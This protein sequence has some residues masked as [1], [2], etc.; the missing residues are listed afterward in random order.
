M[1][2]FAISF[3]LIFATSYLITSVIAP[4]KN[5]LGVIYLFIIAFAQIVFT[6]EILSL[7]SA[8]KQ[9]WVLFLNVLFLI[10]GIF[11]W[12]KNAKPLWS[13]ECKDFRNKVINSFKLDKSLVWLYVGFCIFLIVNTAL[14][15][16]FPIT[17]AD[18]ESYHSA[19]SL[20]WVLQGNL[21]H[22]VVPD[23]RNLCLPINSEILYSWVI[24]FT[25]KDI[26]F[27]FFSFVGYFLSIISLYNILCYC[28]YCTRKKLWI[29]FILSSFASVIVQASSTETDI[30]IAGLTLS[31][32]L[33]FWYGIRNNTKIPIFM[34]SLAYALA[35]G[36][37]TTALM[38]VPGVGILLLAICFYQKKYKPIGYFLMFGVINFV[39]FS[40]YN[41]ILNYVHFSNFM[42]A[43]SFM[44]VSKNYFGIKGM[45]SNF[46]KYMFLMID[47]TG[48]RWSDYFGPQVIAFR[49]N[50]LN[51]IHL[52]Y[53][54]DGLYST[55][56]TVNRY[57][58]EPVMGTG[59]LGI[60]TLIPCMIWSL[61]KPIFNFKNKKAWFTFIFAVVFVVNVLTMSYL[62]AY[63]AFSVRFLMG[64]IVISSPVLVYSYYSNKNPLKYLMIFFALF[65]FICISTH[66]WARPFINLGVI[67]SKHPSISYLRDVAHC[68]DFQENPQYIN[69]NCVL[70]DKMK[71]LFPNKKKILAFIGTSDRIYNFKALE[72]QGYK[73]DFRLL[74]NVSDINFNDYDL[75]ISTDKGQIS[76]LFNEYEQRKDDYVKINKIVHFKKNEEVPCFYTINPNIKGAKNKESLYPFQS[77]CQMTTRFIKKKNLKIIGYAGLFTPWEDPKNRD[78]NYYI[79]YLVDKNKK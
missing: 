72:F 37:K 10:L 12:N 8:I 44:V 2:L 58:L 74:E 35:I 47:F 51:F 40:S 11:V 7:F 41:Y 52:G 65:Y 56:I 66:L 19:R 67:F 70:I 31:T 3:L 64:F 49:D 18:A 53:I 54:K 24:L 75:V 39:I 22:F 4:K 42:G 20:F 28:G 63:M 15:F 48:F 34:A 30:I 78:F 5:I 50:L 43:K 26:F 59:V 60:F 25:K 68:K 6:F 9:F 46:V 79:I 29:I 55:N 57:L 77:K 69:A 73:V 71:L 38:A 45:I 14:C 36:T 32:V 27:G 21:N 61:I 62:L 33:M 23:I 16:L 17:S 13:L 76:T 1:L